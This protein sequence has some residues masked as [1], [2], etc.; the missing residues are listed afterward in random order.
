V[1]TVWRSR[2]LTEEHFDSPGADEALL[3][4]VA[5]GKSGPARPLAG[6]ARRLSGRAGRRAHRAGGRALGRLRTER[7]LTIARPDTA[8]ARVEWLAEM[9]G[10]LR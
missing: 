8:L 5:L 10:V 1:E 2:E 4:G 3:H 7:I 9:I 6:A